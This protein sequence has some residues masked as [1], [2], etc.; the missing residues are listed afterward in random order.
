MRL[1]AKKR[2]KSKASGLMYLATAKQQ[3][4]GG[5]E[6][7]EVGNLGTDV[8]SNCQAAVKRKTTK[9]MKSKNSG[10]TYPSTAKQP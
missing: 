5:R 9:K 7:D 6:E 10:L 8:P 3:E 2:M 1:K 4:A